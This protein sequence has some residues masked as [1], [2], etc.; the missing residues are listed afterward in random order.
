MNMVKNVLCGIT[1]I[2]VYPV[3]SLV[4]FL[5]VFAGA[6]LW[7]ATMK[8]SEAAAFSAMPLNDSTNSREGELQ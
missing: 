1:D 7:A 2:H 3:V 5:L 8:K 4:L 6:L